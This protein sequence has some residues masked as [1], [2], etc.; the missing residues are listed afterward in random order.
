MRCSSIHNFVAVVKTLTLVQLSWETNPYSINMPYTM[1]RANAQGEEFELVGNGIGTAFIDELPPAQK[2]E[3]LVYRVRVDGKEAVAQI[4]AQADAWLLA[5]ADEY[6]W[7]LN[8]IGA[9]TMASIYC[10]K[11]GEGNCPECF[12]DELGKR[13]KANCS[14]CDGSGK[15]TSF[16]GPIPLRYSVL[17]SD[18][19]QANMGDIE[20]EVETISAWTGNIPMINIGDIV[21][22]NDLV[23]YKVQSIP[24]RSIMHSVM[25]GREF[26][27]KQW[28]TL[29][30]LN[31]DEYPMLSYVGNNVEP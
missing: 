8:H 7:Q 5:V 28:I 26:L 24:K 25:D 10:L 13:I 19:M 17:G 4:G 27:A 21:I 23:K 16:T 29:R 3:G 2:R 12:S 15:T 30:K 11:H 22:T 6:I 9:S 14:T 18:R 31:D 20:S 1:Y